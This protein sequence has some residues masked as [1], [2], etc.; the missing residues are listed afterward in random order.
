VK[1]LADRV[2]SGDY[3]GRELRDVGEIGGELRRKLDELLTAA[4]AEIRSA[5]ISA[6][7][8]GYELGYQH[9]SEDTAALIRE[10]ADLA[11][12]AR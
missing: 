4:T 8:N 3:M 9:G 1:T 5:L 10:A 6:R 2:A 12:R 11:S 7:R